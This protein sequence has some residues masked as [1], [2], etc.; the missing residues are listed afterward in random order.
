MQKNSQEVDISKIQDNCI[1]D[2]K[3]SKLYVYASFFLI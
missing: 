2:A 1:M 3:Q